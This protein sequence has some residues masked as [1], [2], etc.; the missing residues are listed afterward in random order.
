[1]IV[2][3]GDA[4]KVLSELDAGIAQCAVTSPP[5]YMQRDYGFEGQIGLEPTPGEYVDRLRSVFA[6]AA[7]VLRPDG[8]LWLNLGDTYNAYNGNRGEGGN[9]N[10]G[11]RHAMLPGVP[12]GYGLTDKS[13]PN[14]CLLGIPWRVADALCVDGWVL[15]AEIIWHKPNGKPGGGKDRPASR[16]EQLFM[17]SRRP[18]YYCAEDIR[19]V[20][21]VWTVPVGGRRRDREH[22]A[23]MADTLAARC[24]QLGSR[25]GD[26][27]LDMFHGSGTTGIAAVD[28]GRRYVGI[29][30]DPGTVETAR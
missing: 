16:H 21:D 9:L 4:G 19:A 10:R 24:I 30:A 12:A 2:Y 26:L 3:R 23:M 5:Y 17:F 25:P 15:R 22:S 13:R 6:E 20:G 7:R 28:L 18:R 27:V 8:T 11:K 29:D 1:M 14:K